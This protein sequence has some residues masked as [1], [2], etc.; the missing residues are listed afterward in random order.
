[1]SKVAIIGGGVAGLTAGHF[2]QQQDIDFMLFEA[3]ARPGG[4]IRTTRRGGYLLESGPHAVRGRNEVLDTVIKQLSLEERIR[5]AAPEAGK[6]YIVHDGRPVAV[7]SGLI[8][9]LKTPLLSTRAKLRLLRE[10]FVSRGG[11]RESVAG[12]VERRLGREA[13]DYLVDP[14]VSGVYAGDPARLSARRAFPGLY[15]L[16]ER[17]GGL[18]M[19]LFKKTLG[20][21]SPRHSKSLSRQPRMYSF[22]GGMQTLPDALASRL[23]EYIR[24]QTPVQ[25][26]VPE[27][28]MWRVI[29]PGGESLVNAV[30]CAAPLHEAPIDIAIEAAVDYPPVAVVSLAYPRALVAHLLDGFGVLVPSVEKQFRILGTLFTSTLFPDRAPEG[31]ALLTSFVGG[32]RAPDRAALDADNLCSL[33]HDDLA[34]L[35][36]ISSAPVFRHHHLWPRAIPQYRPGYESV[37]ARLRQYELEHPG[38]YFAGNYI[39]GVSVGDAM[40][41]GQEAA[42]RCLD[43]FHTNTASTSA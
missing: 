21:M 5:K 1:M 7:P 11:A 22:E 36:G 28:N 14:I 39:S 33:V 37:L 26:V 25:K 15:S 6:R 19:G 35:L 4:K 13:L 32:S 31:Q 9:L 8:S 23:G 3:N 2:L 30:V 20:R 29:F 42:K 41:S 40:K 16:E 43:C 24:L 27:G 17:H 38:I 34:R 10:P 12:F 18:A